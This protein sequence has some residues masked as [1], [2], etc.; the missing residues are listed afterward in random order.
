M[1]RQAAEDGIAVVCATPHIRDD[2]VVKIEEL[3]S[4]VAHLQA[5]IDGDGIP[6]HI[7]LGAEVSQ[8][9]AE[10]SEA[11]ALRQLALGGRSWVLLEPA[12][13]PLGRDLL[14]LAQ[15]LRSERLGVV[16]AHPERHAAA[17]FVQMLRELVEAGCLIQ[18]TAAFVASAE[19]GAVALELAQEGL[20]HLL[21]SDAHSSHGGRPVHLRAGIERL[22]SVCTAAHVSWI[23]YEAPAAVLRGELVRSPS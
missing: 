11:S 3:P 19:H 22:R 15:R 16:I 5:A 17:G 7:A 23:A 13:G 8:R 1:A 20:L 14:Q 12:P 4:R 2:H 10:A 18:W 9:T 6:V 21:G